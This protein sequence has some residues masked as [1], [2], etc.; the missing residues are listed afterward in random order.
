M[1][2][3]SVATETTLDGGS[4]IR[5][6]R[7]RRSAALRDLVA[8]T[9]VLPRQLIMPHFVLPSDDGVEPISSMPGIARMGINDLLRTVER[10][11]ALGIRSVLLFGQPPAGGKNATGTASHDPEGAVPR[12]LRA[13]RTRFGRDLVVITD[14]CLCAYT[15]HGHCGVIVDDEVDNDA[16]LALL[17]EMLGPLSNWLTDTLA[18]GSIQLVSAVKGVFNE[19]EAKLVRTERLETGELE[20][21]EGITVYDTATGEPY[22]MA[23]TN[24]TSVTTAGP[25]VAPI[26]SP[27]SSP[28]T[29]GSASGEPSP[30]PTPSPQE[31]PPDDGELEASPTPEPDPSASPTPEPSVSPSPEPT[32][33]PTPESSPEPSPEPTPDPTV[34]E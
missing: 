1:Q 31:G 13:L 27:S 11:H 12:A 10:D 5:P 23:V 30:S 14:V 32:P 9:T 28:E 8:E 3:W 18:S 33:E 21:R 7:L 2:D 19:L 24:G 29:A 6:R 4:R 34:T 20:V 22:C 26:P 25:C 17:A 16:S 15:D